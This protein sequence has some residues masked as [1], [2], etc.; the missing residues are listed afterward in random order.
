MQ[1]KVSQYLQLQFYNFE[2]MKV[3]KKQKTMV[4]ANKEL[5][6]K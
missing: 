6:W 5:F 1:Y 2:N 4:A 3:K